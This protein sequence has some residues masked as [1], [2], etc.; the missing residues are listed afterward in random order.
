[1]RHW[2]DTY[3]TELISSTNLLTIHANTILCILLTQLYIRNI[4]K[5]KIWWCKPSNILHIYNVNMRWETL[6]IYGIPA[7]LGIVSYKW[8]QHSFQIQ[9]NGHKKSFAYKNAY[10][11]QSLDYCRPALYWATGIGNWNPIQRCWC[12]F[13]VTDSAALL[14]ATGHQPT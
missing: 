11:H 3:K 1:M 2:Y 10:I 9:K 6:N 14:L 5:H 4:W 12:K 13:S 8:L 7:E